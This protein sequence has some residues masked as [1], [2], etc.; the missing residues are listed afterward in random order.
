MQKDEDNAMM[1]VL[2]ATK[3]LNL[4]E[5]EPAQSMAVEREQEEVIKKTPTTDE[6]D[7]IEREQEEVINETPTTDEIDVIER[8]QE[9]VFSKTPIIDEIDLVEREQEDA[10]NKNVSSNSTTDNGLNSLGNCIEDKRLIQEK[11]TEDTGKFVFTLC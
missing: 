11:L 6:I 4:V 5:N 9:E 1:E 2:D 3:K 8:E 10:I 7:L